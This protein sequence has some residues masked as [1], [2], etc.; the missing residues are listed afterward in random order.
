MVTMSLS[1]VDAG[2]AHCQLVGQLESQHQWSAAEQLMMTMCVVKKGRTATT[3]TS[4]KGVG[5]VPLSHAPNSSSTR[6]G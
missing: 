2:L 6:E 1:S 3:N 4:V 5:G